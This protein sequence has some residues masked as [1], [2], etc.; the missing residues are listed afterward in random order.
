MRLF[1]R[2]CAI[3]LPF[4]FPFLAVSGHAQEASKFCN[5]GVSAQS[6]LSGMSKSLPSSFGTGIE[7]LRTI[8][9]S[10]GIEATILPSS[11]LNERLV[12][13]MN[14]G[15]IPLDNGRYLTVITDIR[16]PAIANK[17]DG[18]FHPFDEGQVITALKE[19]S[20][21]GLHLNVTIYILP[22][23][24]R[25]VILSSANGHEIYLSPHV[26]E[27]PYNVCAYIVTH[28]IGHVFQFGN[29]PE[30]D[31]ENWDAYK[32]LRGIDNPLKFYET[33][34]H[35]YRPKE[36]FA[37]DFRVLFGGIAAKFGGIVENPE[38]LSPLQVAGLEAFFLSLKPVD[39]P[40]ETIVALNGFPNPF[41]PRTQI[42]V[43]L[44][45]AFALGTDRLSI[46]IYDVNGAL[47]RE[48]YEGTPASRE[49][50]IDWN[51]A[52]NNG[53]QVA[54]ATYFALVR[55]GEVRKTVKLLMLK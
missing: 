32:K 38:L 30:S 53:T 5:D 55:A 7:G 10:N 33:A 11:Y 19:I 35:A 36:V 15:V 6:S 43:E 18:A 31:V 1:Y 37:E 8:S 17:G 47:V 29:L 21:P 45:N 54:S 40:A 51:G 50:R 12:P 25:N 3:G 42:R 22:Y 9:L 26:L 27:I 14:G 52:A 4:L 41:N 24:R 13:D 20:Y 16:D 23:P 46:R 2:I 34:P 48:L 49:V 28:E 39:R 44:G